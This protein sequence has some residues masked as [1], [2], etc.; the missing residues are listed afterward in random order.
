[1]TKAVPVAHQEFQ[2]QFPRNEDNLPQ[3][4]EWCLVQ[5]GDEEKRIRFHDYGRIFAEPGLYEHLFYDTLKCDSPAIVCDLLE[6]TVEHHTDPVELSDLSVLDIG[7]GNGIVGEEL[8]KRGVDGIVGLDLIPE[9]AAA[10]ERDRSGVYEDYLVADLTELDDSTR[11]QLE[12]GNFDCMVT[13]AALGF[14]DIPPAAFAEAFNLITVPGWVA[15]NIR[16]RFL[17]TEESSGFSSLIERMI[18][19][20]VLDSVSQ[21]KYRHRFGVNGQPLYYYAF[22]ARKAAEIPA[23]W[24]GQQ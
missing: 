13:V 17:E 8:Q 24:V 19:E 2:V 5:T 23:E 6:K 10:A 4:E 18:D 21:R 11:T 3:D 1:M 22:A 14:G 15:F 9:A 12:D 20:Q 16:D 7:A